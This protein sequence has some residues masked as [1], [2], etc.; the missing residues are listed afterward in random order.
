MTTNGS[1]AVSKC[2]RRLKTMAVV[3]AILIG[4]PWAFLELQPF[5]HDA[6]SFEIAQGCGTDDNH[7]KSDRTEDSFVQKWETGDLVIGASELSH[8]DQVDSVSAQVVAGHLFLRL[9]YGKPGRPPTACLC[10]HN[11]IIRLKGVDDR[12]YSIHRVGFA[13]LGG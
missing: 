1:A 12:I 4:V 8:C 13:R 7:S 6:I 5:R 9:K 11:T 2:P 10:R 3:I